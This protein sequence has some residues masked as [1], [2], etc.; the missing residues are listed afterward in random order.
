MKG[1]AKRSQDVCR[2]QAGTNQHIMVARASHDP[3]IKSVGKLPASA[4]V[5]DL[6]FDR[7]R[8]PSPTGK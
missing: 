5:S 2:V 3:C 6:S 8:Q 1:W 7:D 4:L